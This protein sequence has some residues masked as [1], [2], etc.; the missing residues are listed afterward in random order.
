[1]SSSVIFICIYSLF[2]RHAGSSFYI[3][4]LQTNEFIIFLF[5]AA[6]TVGEPCLPKQRYSRGKSEPFYIFLVDWACVGD[7][8]FFI[9]LYVNRS[10]RS[11]IV[12]PQKCLVTFCCFVMFFSQTDI[13]F[14]FV[15]S[16]ITRSCSSNSCLPGTGISLWYVC[17][18][19]LD[20][21][22]SI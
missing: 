15:F 13:I 2:H 19:C 21:V 1:M 8:H 14:L 9:V 17:L 18:I 6:K 5:L 7:I 12:L 3:C 16:E 11:C 22:V 20:T 4:A 10:L